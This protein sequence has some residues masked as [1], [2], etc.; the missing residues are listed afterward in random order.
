MGRVDAKTSVKGQTTIPNEVRKALGLQPGGQ[1]QY[2]IGDD[3]KVSLIAKTHGIR[4]LGGL[5]EHLPPAGKTDDEQIMEA[6][7][8]KNQPGRGA[9][10]S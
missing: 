5:F 3:G 9:F 4:H 7:W 2:C 8:H 1:V 6:V 10:K